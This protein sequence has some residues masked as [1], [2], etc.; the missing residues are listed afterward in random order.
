MENKNNRE[1]NQRYQKLVL[2]E[3]INKM[4]KSPAIL[5]RKKREVTSLIKMILKE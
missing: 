3:K 1:K 5:S 4:D 2:S